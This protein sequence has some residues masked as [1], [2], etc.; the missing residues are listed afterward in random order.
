MNAKSATELTLL[1]GVCISM[2]GA[3]EHVDLFY[4]YLH[5]SVCYLDK[6]ETV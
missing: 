3:L 5:R 4:T 6:R 1:K 2:S